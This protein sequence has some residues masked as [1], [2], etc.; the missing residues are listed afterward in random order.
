MPGYFIDTSALV[1]LYHDE[2]GAEAVREIFADSQST[3]F[4]SRLC[5]LETQSALIRK[6]RERQIDEEQFSIYRV[7]FLGDVADEIVRVYRTPPHYLRTA[8]SLLLKYGA[9]SKLRTL[10]AIQLAV[11]TDALNRDLLS[12]FVSADVALCEV[13]A[14]EGFQTINPLD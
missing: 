7:G 10:D 13:A 4:I 12:I 8:E 14:Q 3:C 2:V 11:A 9:S 1:K 5:V 6:I